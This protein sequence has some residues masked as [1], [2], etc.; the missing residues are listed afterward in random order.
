MPFVSKRMMLR[1]Y[2]W[3][4]GYCCRK[5]T[6]TLQILSKVICIGHSSNTP[7]KCVNL[8]ILQALSK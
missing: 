4:N 2:L 6:A 5:S 3:H 8:T 7:G 1:K